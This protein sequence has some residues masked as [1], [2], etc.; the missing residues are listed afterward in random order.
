MRPRI[1]ID[2]H[3]VG[4]QETGN[5]TYV[6]NL[7]RALPGADRDRQFS[8]KALT[9]DPG[10]LQAHLG[11]GAGLEAVRVRPAS[12]LVRIPVS[13]PLLAMRERFDLLHMTYVAPP[14]PPCPVV[15]TVH[16]ISYRLYPQYFPARVRWMLSLLVPISMR[17]AAKVITVS[18]SAKRDILTHYNVPEAKVT[19]THEAAPPHF[20]Q[21]AH[22]DALAGVKAQYGIETD[23]IL[24]V[25]NLQPRKNIRRLVEAY[26]KMPADLRKRYKLVV[27]GQALWQHSDIYRAVT[28]RGLLSDV[29]FTG[30][31]PEPDLV[32]LYNTAA[33]FAYPSLYEGFGLPVLEAMACGT[34]VVTSNLSSLPEIAG[35]AALLVDPA[36]ETAISS[37]MA[38]LLSDPHLAR[39]LSAAGLQRARSFSWERT[40]IETLKIYRDVIGGSSHGL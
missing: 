38:T 33:L 9:L 2:A 23:F 40:A 11:A 17:R 8:Y 10:T 12:S 35:D 26:G 7:L 1:A 39:R 32:L 19:V 20:R 15:V 3:M 13:V 25:G 14:T 22:R 36:D 29:I 30:Y 4:S 18:H 5:E 24:S 21:V 6:V 27:V 31:V 28:D 34:P 16:D 37:A